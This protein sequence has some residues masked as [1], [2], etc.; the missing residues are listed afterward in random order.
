MMRGCCT[1]VMRPK[2]TFVMVPVGSIA[3]TAFGTLNASS[4]TSSR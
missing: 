3:R 4:L 2:L 1:A